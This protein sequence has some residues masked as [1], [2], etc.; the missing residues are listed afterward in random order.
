MIFT[1]CQNNLVCGILELKSS[2]VLF[3]MRF[4]CQWLSIFMHLASKLTNLY[5]ASDYRPPS[6]SLTGRGMP[7]TV[8]SLRYRLFFHGATTDWQRP[9]WAEDF[10]WGGQWC[11]HTHPKFFHRFIDRGY[12]LIIINRNVHSMWEPFAPWFRNVLCMY[13]IEGVGSYFVNI[14]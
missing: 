13:F 3:F 10:P 12:V 4:W 2:K 6:T 9:L 7:C 11:T 8:Y 5:I 1:G 14:Q